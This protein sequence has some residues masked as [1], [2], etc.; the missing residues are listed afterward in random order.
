MVIQ[1]H[2]A[3]SSVSASSKASPSRCVPPSFLPSLLFFSGS[4]SVTNGLRSAFLSESQWAEHDGGQNLN[5]LEG[6]LTTP[7]SSAPSPSRSFCSFPFHSHIALF[8]S[9]LLHDLH[10]AF[11]PLFLLHRAHSHRVIVDSEFGSHCLPGILL[12]LFGS[13]SSSVHRRAHYDPYLTSYV[14]AFFSSPSQPL[15]LGPRATDID[16]DIDIDIDFGLN[17]DLDA[18]GSGSDDQ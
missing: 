15:R 8:L 14:S 12:S 17:S 3:G 13:P 11:S 18:A 6:T 4:P 16:F 1:G 2:Q 10:F 7:F 9:F 5:I